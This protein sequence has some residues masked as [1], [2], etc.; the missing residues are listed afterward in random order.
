VGQALWECAYDLETGQLLSATLMDCALPRADALSSFTTEISEAPSTS[1]PL[2][3]RGGG[4]GGT[5]PGLGAVGNA[6]C[7]ALAELGVEH[8]ELPAI[9]A[10]AW[11]A[12]RDARS[13]TS[14]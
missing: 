4:E 11:R 9:P 7:H 3:L 10:R 8:V 14:L 2:G 12:I 6:I 13:R 1:P 5:A